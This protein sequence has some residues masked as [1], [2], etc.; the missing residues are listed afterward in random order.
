MQDVDAEPAHE[1]DDL[2]NHPWIVLIVALHHVD[3]H[4]VA[5]GGTDE[6][7]L[8]GFAAGL[9]HAEVQLKPVAIDGPVRF[10][11]RLAGPPDLGGVAQMEHVD[12]PAAPGIADGS[13]RHHLDP[14]R[15]SAIPA[16]RRGSSE[17]RR[18]RTSPRSCGPSAMN[19]AGTT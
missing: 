4:A 2:L 14:E 1:A 3:R 13:H 9:E 7:R 5:P 10:Q 8:A 18:L 12:D 17:P 11:N 16:S 19:H 6:R 15:A